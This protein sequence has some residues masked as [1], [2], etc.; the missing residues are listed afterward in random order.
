MSKKKA[1]YRALQKARHSLLRAK[2]CADGPY[3]A[4]KWVTIDELS[5]MYF[6]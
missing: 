2:R 1:K 3:F 4:F 5:K 6:T